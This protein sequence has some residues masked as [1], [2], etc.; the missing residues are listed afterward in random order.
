[1]CGIIVTLEADEEA[2]RGF[3]IQGIQYDSGSRIIGSF[4]FVDADT[5]SS[6]DCLDGL[7]VGYLKKIYI[8]M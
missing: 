4:R 8:L 2:F 7:D 3:L 1:M 5:G 6:M